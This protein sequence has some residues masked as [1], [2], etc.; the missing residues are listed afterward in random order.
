MNSVLPLSSERDLPGGRV[1]IALF[2][3]LVVLVAALPY[4]GTLDAP[5][6][7][8]DTKLVRDNELIRVSGNAALP[9]IAKSFNIFSREWV[10]ADLRENYRPLRFLSYWIDYRLSVALLDEFHPADPPV[11]FFH[12]QNIFWHALNAILVFF[13]GRH[14]L[15]RDTGGL[16]AALLFASHPLFTEAVTYISSR[17]DVISTFFFLAALL[18]YVRIP[19][20]SKLPIWCAIT[21]PLLFALGFFAKEMVVTLPALV[22]LVD[23]LRRPKLD[24]SRVACHLALWT[25]AGIFIYATM[26]TPNMIR[27]V[28]E[29][30]EGSVFL[31]ACRYLG[32]YFGLVVAPF[33]LSLDYSFDAISP[34]RSLA[35]PWTTIPA[36]LLVLG[37][38]GASFWAWRTKRG[39]V[40]L[41][42]LWFV[43]VLVP[44]LQFVPTAERFAERFAYLPALGL[45]FLVAAVFARGVR[46]DP[47]YGS[48]F[49]GLVVLVAIGLTVR[50]NADWD[51]KLGIWGAT[52][53]AQPNCA[54]AHKAYANA[55]VE[56]GKMK[57]AV[58]ELTIAIDLWGAKENRTRL[59]RGLYLHTRAERGSYLR[60]LAK[61]DARLL[62]QAIADLEFVLGSKDTDNAGTVIAE[63]MNPVYQSARFGLADA[64]FRAERP[65]DAV[66]EFEIL[67]E[68]RGLPAFVLKSLYTL[69]IIHA[70]AKR[71]DSAREALETAIGM[72][73][74]TDSRRFD[75]QRHLVVLLRDDQRDA[76]AARAYLEACLEEPGLTKV[77]RVEF[78]F[79]LAKTL[80][81][82][83]ELDGCADRLDELLEID[84][85]NVGALLSLADIE[86]KRRKYDKAKKLYGRVLAIDRRNAVADKG[87]REILLQSSVESDTG[88]N[89]V[90]GEARKELESMAASADKHYNN[91][92]WDA[93]RQSWNKIR[94]KAAEL[95]QNDYIAKAYRGMAAAEI[96][97][98]RYRSAKKWLDQALR[99]DEGKLETLQAIGDLRLQYLDDSPGAIEA[100]R[101]YLALVPDE[102]EGDPSVLYNLAS[103]T[104]EASHSEALGLF[105]RAKTAG[106]A[107]K[108]GDRA[109]ELDKQMG[110]L[111]AKAEKWQE[112][113]DALSAVIRALGDKD[114]ESRLSIERFLNERVLPNLLGEDPE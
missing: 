82:L 75:F 14:F 10:D 70:K 100:Y 103:L 85:T 90:R 99:I 49:V 48:A 111:Y 107:E 83:A 71:F 98:R 4:V 1:G 36:L 73:D 56:D 52:V 8:D 40:A 31:T 110:F 93:A 28:P 61:N 24:A 50:R 6:V 92:Q 68:R 38:L 108:L 80:N 30:G 89:T 32:R 7:F 2:L 96:R 27:D 81:Q 41:G 46:K 87:L 106:I 95:R 43:G 29:S 76:K 62:D 105:E 51:T 39:L 13:L 66:R 19:A 20:T 16:I 109:H 11:F 21:A 60:A 84:P 22:L 57:R 88:T 113:F 74:R 72:L 53:E 35:D 67:V 33:S 59:E 69:H 63:S 114:V 45:V 65:D 44:V 18:V 12:L 86:S 26:T 25:V 94:E 102:E 55:L 9:R 54:R 104:Q 15:G 78:L 17:R 77:Q 91:E 97:L 58:E 42:L 64:Y 37:M 112:S 5:F 3:F 47:V 101:E 34:T 23:I 79:G